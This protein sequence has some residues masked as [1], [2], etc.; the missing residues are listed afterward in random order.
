MAWNEN[1]QNI[2]DHVEYYLQQKEEPVNVDEI[3]QLAGCSYTFFQKVFSYMNGIG[4][5]EYIRYR[6][7]T[8]A[9]YDLKSTNIKVIDLSYK[10]GYDSPTSFTKAFQQFHGFSPTEARKAGNLLRVYPKMQVCDRL[11][12]AWRLEDK[13]PLRLIGVC[14]RISLQGGKSHLQIPEF[15]NECQRNGIFSK[16]ISMDTGTPK[17]LFGVFGGIDERTDDREY[18]LMV[19]SDQDIP[20]GYHEKF[21]SANT[22]AIFDC[23][24][25]VPQSIQRGWKY[26]SEEWLAKY[27]FKHAPD[28]EL[29]WYSAGNPYSEHYLSQIWIPIITEE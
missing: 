8:L 20:T 16:L 1:L 23:C 21:I 11:Q 6:K 18:F 26:L 4:F 13:P 24:G 7:L 9:G 28:P 25:S 10:Y 3:T 2:I 27:P 15:W 14:A 22:W 5:A 17:G 29:E 12:Y 19:N